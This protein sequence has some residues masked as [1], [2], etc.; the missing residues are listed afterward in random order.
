MRRMFRLPTP[1]SVLFF[2]ALAVAM[3]LVNLAL[4]Q[5][6]PVAFLLLYAALVCGR[7]PYAVACA[8]LLSSV[9]ALSWE[10]TLAMAAQGVILMLAFVLS[11]SFHREPGPER[12]AYA[13]VAQLPGIFLFPHTGYALFPIPVIAQKCILALFLLLAALLAEGG[14]RALLFRV[15]RCRLSGAELAQIGLLWLFLGMGLYAGLGQIA[16]TGVTLT[17]L[18]AAVVLTGNAAAVPF[19]VALALPACVYEVSFLPV[20]LYA[21]YACAAL[22]LHAY[23][24][25]A[26]ALAM[27]L[28][29][30]AVQYF[31]GL[32]TQDAV[33]ISL[34][35]L[36]CVLPALVLAL[37][38]ERL[39]MRAKRSLLF[40][41]ERVLPRI[42]VNRNRRAVGE[43]LY[44]VSALFREIES[45]FLI[46]ETTEDAD[47]RIAR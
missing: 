40:Y 33:T 37:L 14:M 34:T 10:A 45:S 41:R 13:A 29:F 43:Q 21:L 24:R 7:N 42:A 25:I 44:E 12:I 6:E 46:P 47:R 20:A 16:Y 19:A 30:L 36:A 39:M 3:V 18:L 4:P 27:T 1:R 23:G 8:Y 28:T 11:R 9:A 35:V 31:L 17:L 26:A 2:C 38:P 32:Y 22:L 5:R 15:F